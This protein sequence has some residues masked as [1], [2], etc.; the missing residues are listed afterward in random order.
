MNHFDA[1][2]VAVPASHAWEKTR[3][4]N[5][6]ARYFLRSC[7]W[8]HCPCG[9]ARRLMSKYARSIVETDTKNDPL[10]QRTFPSKSDGIAI[11]T[12]D[13][14]TDSAKH[15]CAKSQNRFT[16]WTMAF[17]STGGR[18]AMRRSYHQFSERRKVRSMICQ[19]VCCN[20]P[21]SGAFAGRAF[22]QSIGG[23]MWGKAAHPCGA[24][25][26][27]RSRLEIT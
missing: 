12:A 9:L 13:S 19:D 22:G 24:A 8:N 5:S 7:G 20:D 21:D 23:T 16:R 4:V 18:D 1:I 17:S 15:N 14:H 26:S 25:S 6:A 3:S 10:A 2:N 27:G 11:P